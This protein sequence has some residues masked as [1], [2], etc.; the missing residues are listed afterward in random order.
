[1][2]Q[3]IFLSLAL[4]TCVAVI[5]TGCGG[6]GSD[7]PTTPPAGTCTSTALATG[8]ADTTFTVAGWADRDYDLVLPASHVCGQAI[9]VVIVLHGGGSNKEGMRK[10]T[11]PDGDLADPACLDHVAAAAGMAVV[12]ANGTNGP[13]AKLIDPKGV[14]TFNAGGGQSGYVC[15]SGY[16]CDQGIDDIGYVRALLADLSA[17]VVVDPK[18]VYATGF[19]NGGAMAQRI[20]CQAADV[21]AAVAP[22]SGEN[23]FAL[24]GCTPSQPVAVLDIHGT[25]DACWPYAGGNGGCIDNGIYVSVETTL[26]GWAARN[27]CVATPRSTMLPPLAGVSDGTSVV[28]LDYDDCDAGGELAHLEVVGNGHFWPRGFAYAS[29]AILGGTMSRQLDTNQAIVDF[30]AAHARP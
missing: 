28:R 2:G 16:A 9:A 23:Q 4:A 18:R 8:A 27:G 20:A 26:A 13:L 7:P 6:G 24:G 5:A 19:S 21:F 29:G 25:L 10:L 30:F 15:A 3:R 14:R 11:C 22:V 12:F 17:H 1:M